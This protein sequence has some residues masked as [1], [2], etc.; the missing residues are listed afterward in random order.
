MK[1]SG[2]LKFSAVYVIK[3]IVKFGLQVCI[4][5]NIMNS[6]LGFWTKIWIHKSAK[7]EMLT[8][9]LSLK[10]VNLVVSANFTYGKAFRNQ[11]SIQYIYGKTMYNLNIIFNLLWT[12]WTEYFGNYVQIV[13]NF[14]IYVLNRFLI[15]KNSSICQ[16]S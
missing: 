9:F 8:Y 6:C 1:F 2:T 10:V 4:L 7:T 14:P 11:K 12:I 16:I 15:S 5:E 3:L 13:H